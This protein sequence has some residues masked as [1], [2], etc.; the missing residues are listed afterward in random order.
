MKAFR[1]LQQGFTEKSGSLGHKQHSI[2]QSSVPLLMQQTCMV[3]I[4]SKFPFVSQ[5]DLQNLQISQEDLN[6]KEKLTLP[7]HP[8]S[9]VFSWKMLFLY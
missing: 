6:E 8:H 1:E 5:A 3:Y 4:N 7:F 9:C 2:L